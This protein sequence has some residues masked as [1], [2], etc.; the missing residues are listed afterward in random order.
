[1]TAEKRCRS[2]PGNGTRAAE[3]QSIKLKHWAMG[4]APQNIFLVNAAIS[5]FCSIQDAHYDIISRTILE[6]RLITQ[7]WLS[8]YQCAVIQNLI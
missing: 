2:A 1:M 3:V 4:P 6:H 5:D 8:R 7:E